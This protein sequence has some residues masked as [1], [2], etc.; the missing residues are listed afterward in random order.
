MLVNIDGRDLRYDIVGDERA[1]R[2]AGALGARVD[3][4]QLGRLCAGRRPRRADAVVT[5]D[6]DAVAEQAVVAVCGGPA[7]VTGG[8]VAAR[9]SEEEGARR[10]Q[11]S[12]WHSLHG[13]TTGGLRESAS[14]VILRT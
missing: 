5:A 10:E 9:G 6:F 8:D 11:R 14:Y 7:I 4:T 12:V 2:G 13:T 1:L 3:A